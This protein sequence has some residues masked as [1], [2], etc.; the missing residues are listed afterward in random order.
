M[1]VKKKNV[2]RFRP[3]EHYFPIEIIE[4]G[5]KGIM[6]V[7]RSKTPR[8]EEGDKADF[9]AKNTNSSPNNALS[10]GFFN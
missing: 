2:D 9:L 3:F 5:T 10:I 8:F 1:R 7:V 4:F 6:I